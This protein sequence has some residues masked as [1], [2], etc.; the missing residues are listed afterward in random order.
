MFEQQFPICSSSSS[1]EREKKSLVIFFSFFLEKQERIHLIYDC[2][3]L[4]NS[5]FKQNVIFSFHLDLD[6]KEFRKKSSLAYDGNMGPRK[7]GIFKNRA[8]E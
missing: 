7:Y 8:P 6:R 5:D 4:K 2:H 1:A 3:D